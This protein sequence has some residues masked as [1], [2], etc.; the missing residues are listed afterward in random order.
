[1]RLRKAKSIALRDCKEVNSMEAFMDPLRQYI[2]M[3]VAILDTGQMVPKSFTM[4]GGKRYTIDEIVNVRFIKKEEPSPIP[5]KNPAPWMNPAALP[6]RANICELPTCDEY[7]VSIH[8]QKAKLYFEPW[9]HTTGRFCGR[10]FVITTAHKKSPKG[11]QL[12]QSH[13]QG[14]EK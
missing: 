4:D 2:T 8:G 9:P 3:D 7:T 5:K 14:A 11:N 1:M 12:Y 13:S 10:W 6:S